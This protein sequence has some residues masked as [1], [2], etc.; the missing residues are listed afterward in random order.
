MQTGLVVIG[1][2]E[3]QRLVACL[4][5]AVG[6]GRP[7]VYVD[8]GSSDG[9]VEAALR[10]G[11]EVVA[12]DM[13]RPFTAARAR[14]EGFARLNQHHPGLDAVQFIDGDCVMDQGW[15]PAAERFLAEHPDVAA[16]AGRLRERHPEAS[17]YNAMADLEWNIP[18]GETQAVGGIALMRVKAFTACGGFDEALIAGEEPELCVRLRAHGWRIW[19]LAESMAMHDMA[20]TRFSQWMRRSR[21]AGF[22]FASVAAKHWSSPQAI[23]KREV[24]RALFWGLALPVTII[25][26]G[27][28]WPE[29]FALLLIYPLQMTRLALRRGWSYGFLITTAKFAEAAGVL[30]YA[31]EHIGGRKR[32]II[33]HK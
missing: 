21:R 3:G 6:Q 25:V 17:V 4:G 13:A 24:L 9:S 18:E 30:S 7:A 2:N 23:W 8:S 22:A 19:R 11:A 31:V 33:E 15:L 10:L 20:M 1:R 16:V 14:N 12:L 27:Y 28:I 26:L 5:S 29:L 32:E